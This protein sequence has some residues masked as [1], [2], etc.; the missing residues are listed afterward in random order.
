M[1]LPYIF[2]FNI[3]KTI[4]G[5]LY[6][7]YNI[8]KNININD[9]DNDND[10]DKIYRIEEFKEKFIR[11]NFKDFI[12]F[13]KNKYKTVEFYCIFDNDNKYDLNIIVDRIEKYSNIKFNKPYFNNNNNNNN[14]N[15]D[16]DTDNEDDNKIILSNLYDIIIN[17]LISKYQSLKS[18]K[19]K[20]Y[21]FNNQ[22]LYIDYIAENIKDFPQKQILCPKYNYKLYYEHNFKIYENDIIYQSILNLIMEKYSEITIKHMN[23]NFFNN[24]I[25]I[26]KKDKNLIIDNN[27]I[28]TINEKLF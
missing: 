12:K 1:K 2:I 15:N 16:T 14:N 18:Q 6:S 26:L 9:N 27:K 28:K 8:I 5:D 17:D 21:V 23:D 25:A 7:L 3:D 4:I 13:V 11:P 19:N 24:L 20:E 22:I 10:N